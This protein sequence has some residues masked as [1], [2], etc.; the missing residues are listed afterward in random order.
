MLLP[1]KRHIKNHPSAPSIFYFWSE[2]KGSL[3][4]ANTCL[5]SQRMLRELVFLANWVSKN[6]FIFWKHCRK[7]NFIIGLISFLKPIIKPKVEAMNRYSLLSFKGESPHWC[8]EK[9]L[10]KSHCSLKLL[11]CMYIYIYSHNKSLVVIATSDACILI[12]CS[13]ALD[14]HDSLLVSFKYIHK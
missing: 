1:Y 8:L 7:W 2:V 11:Y 14:M 4:V 9:F 10:I 13:P 3:A 12:H 5:S 6:K